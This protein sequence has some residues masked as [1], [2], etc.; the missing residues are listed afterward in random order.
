MPAEEEPSRAAGGCVLV[1]L[2]AVVVGAAFAVDEAVGVLGVVVAG[3]VALWRCARRVSDSSA[4]PPPGVDRPSCRECAGHEPLSA[5]PL[6][7]QKGM[8]IYT[9]ATPDRPNYTHVHIERT[10]DETHD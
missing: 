5:T 8:L 9:S 3:T 4:P 7:I 1:V 10:A 6:E 2:A